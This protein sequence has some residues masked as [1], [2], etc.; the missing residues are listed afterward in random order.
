MKYMGSKRRIASEI[1]PIILANRQEDQW[2]VEPFC[3]GCNLIDKIP[4]GIGRLANDVHV[5]LISLLKALQDGWQPPTEVSEKDYANARKLE[6]TNPLKGFI[7]F[8]SSYSGKWFGGFARGNTNKGVP[9]NYTM[10]AFNNIKAQ[11]PNLIGIT[12]SSGNYFDLTIPPNSLIYCDPPY[13]GTTSYK[14]KFNHEDFYKW[15]RKKKADG[16]TI[17]ISE[18]FMPEDF[19]C[20]WSKE[21]V[22]SL[23]QDTG[24][25]VAT[26][27]LF[28]L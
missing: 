24:S 21:Q 16:H 8:C 12:F 19:T 3:G 2:Y 25:K 26:E 5:S 17:F 14:D 11:L 1:L 22:S 13:K 28:T 15:C 7:G 10:E 20:V 23:T 4:Q 9:R 18:Y 27:R 6:D